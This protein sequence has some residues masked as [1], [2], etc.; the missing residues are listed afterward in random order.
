M[1][2]TVTY[3]GG[4]RYDI[5]SGRHTVVTDQPVEDGGADAGLTPVDLLAGSLASCV[6]YYVGSYCRRHDLPH[7]GFSGAVD[8]DMAEQ[9]HR[10]GRFILTINLPQRLNPFERDRLLRVAEGCTVHRTLLHPPEVRIEYPATEQSVQER[11][12]S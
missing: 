3:R 2:M 9:P 5:Q 6:A 7:D 12:R 4:T 8:Y 11:Q 1:G 10:V